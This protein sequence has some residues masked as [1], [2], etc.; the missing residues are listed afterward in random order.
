MLKKPPM[1]WLTP[2]FPVLKRQRQAS[3]SLLGAIQASERPCLKT[4][5]NQTKPKEVVVSRTLKDFF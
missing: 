5:P 1:W 2:A 3:P 4:K